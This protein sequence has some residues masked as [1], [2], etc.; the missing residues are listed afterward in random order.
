MR[1]HRMQAS[2]G[3]L[4][5][6]VLELRD[7]LNILQAPNEAGKSTWCAFLLAMF[8]GIDT[9]ER[10]R[11]GFIADKN[12][13]APWNGAPMGGRLD[14]QV[15]QENLTLLRA[16]CRQNAPMR[17]FQALYA[18]TQTAVLGLTGENCGETL[19]GVSRE[20]Y[21]RSA[22]I[23]QS[24]LPI[25]PDAGL[26]RRVASLI[27]SG[28]EGVSY[29]EAAKVLRDQLNRRRHN[30]TGRLPSL[31]AE[32]AATRSLQNTQ[33][34][35]L[36]QLEEAREQAK[37]L[38]ARAAEL[39]EELAQL[40]RWEAHRQR[41]ILVDAEEAAERAEKR[42]LELR[43]RL[44]ES[45]VPENDAI[46]RLRGAIVN[47]ETVR[48]ST[49]KALMQRDEAIT[50]KREAEAA[51][52][53]S[54]FAGMTPEEAEQQP[55][56][57][58]PKP[59]FPLLAG[60]LFVILG[61]AL[62]GAVYMAQ[63]GGD[64]PL[65]VGCGCGL[66]G[67]GWLAAALV[68]RKRQARWKAQAAEVRGERNKALEVYKSLC[69]AAENAR[70]EA[71]VKIAAADSLYVSLSTNEEA[72][73]REIR[74]FAPEAYDVISG[75]AALRGCAIRRKE[76]AEADAAAREARL[77]TDVLAQQFPEV[78]EGTPLTPPVRGRASI[79]AEQEKNREELIAARS[80]AD[81]LS[82]RFHA[83]G[84]PLV[85]ESSAGRLIEQIA[86]IE[87]EYEA[88]ELA[89][90]ALETANNRLQQRFSPALGCRAEEIF[91]ALTAGAYDS[92]ALDRDFH[93]S[94]EPSDTGIPREAGLLSGGA[95]DQL[96]LAVRLA[97]CDLVLPEEQAAP[98]VLDDALSNFDDE[99]CA[100]A[101]TWLRKEAEKRQILLFTCHSREAEFFA[102]DPEVSVQRLTAFAELV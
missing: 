99:R 88:I 10:N 67:A 81:Q 41:Q 80:K 92:V 100:A 69:E 34:E 95:A 30:K 29:S 55:L 26:E 37:T 47:L 58:P 79:L 78:G 38:E 2:F 62:G 71:G 15:D 35:L 48:K 17:E 8:Y 89:L 6:E 46:G 68:T 56:D 11:T 7:G 19:L 74:R 1:I 60:V 96:Y 87:Q 93:V 72:I 101:L 75:D 42:A 31:E 5:G 25:T 51:M 27:T 32:L 53:G 50:A 63:A 91:A 39:E 23:R 94:A 44:E 16:T 57:L 102:E 97:I 65:A 13:Y 70:S 85:L 98:I 43:R 12:R 77:R 24:G 61:L 83:T 28:E 84:D 73:L 64:I 82:G 49:E 3:K 21:A 90:S 14:C 76:L 45:Q 20:V 54:P 33:A 66:A 18:G 40:D 86:G 4:Q 22:F 52:N 36:R 9:R 59:K